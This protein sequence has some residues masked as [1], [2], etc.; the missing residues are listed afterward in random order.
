MRVRNSGYFSSRT[1]KLQKLK[2]T[3]AL[4]NQLLGA[5]VLISDGNSEHVPIAS[6]KKSI[7]D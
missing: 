5:I 2:T 7:C 3:Q 4:C 1:R 6:R